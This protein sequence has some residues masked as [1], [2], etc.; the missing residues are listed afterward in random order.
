MIRLDGDL[1]CLETDHTGYYMAR[2]GALL[3]TLHYGTKIQ[4]D[5]PALREKTGAGYGTDVVVAGAEPDS[6]LHLC[7]EL[8]P[9]GRGDFRMGM[10]STLRTL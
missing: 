10:V 4:P 1:I 3:E 9:D 2:R 7:L 8:T 5:V 6:L